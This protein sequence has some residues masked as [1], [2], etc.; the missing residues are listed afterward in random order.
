MKATSSKKKQGKGTQEKPD[1]SAKTVSPPIWK[2]YVKAGAVALVLAL[3]I[4][5]YVAQAFKIPSE[6]MLQTL[7]VGDHLL[8]NKMAYR[9]TE[10]ARGDIIVFKYPLDKSRDFVKR[11]IGLP[12]ETVAM[13]GN[14][15]FINGKKLNEPYAIYESSPFHLDA[16][17]S[18]G[19][20]KVPEGYY[21]MMGD[22]RNNSQDS[23]VWGPL[24]GNLIHG[25]AFILHWS[26]SGDGYGV[27]MN[28]IGKLLY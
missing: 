1:N 19:P 23:R 5:T 14:N 11:L 24:D 26:W 22:N 2:E 10:P 7:Q 18:F 16:G 20:I 28:R 6:S 27:R 9:F 15:V 17:Y 25:N 4:R 12:R 21:F 3:F 8:V 13:K